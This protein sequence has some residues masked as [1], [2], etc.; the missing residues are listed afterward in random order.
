M[1]SSYSV[2]IFTAGVVFVFGVLF[3]RKIHKNTHD[4]REMRKI[5]LKRIESLPLP[6]MLQ[7]L[8]IS[9]TDY[10]YKVSVDDIDKSISNC[11]KCSSTEIC[12]KK[13]KLPELNPGDIDFCASRQHLSKFSRESRVKG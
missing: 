6:K 11:E 2:V 4:R 3:M 1:F 5:L 10:F 12:N 8:G 13:L 7:A 9:F